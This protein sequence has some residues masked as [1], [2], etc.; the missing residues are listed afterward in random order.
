MPL[1]LGPITLN[2]IGNSMTSSKQTHTSPASRA[3]APASGSNHDNLP[4]PC[5][6]S[7]AE[8]SFHNRDR[9]LETL[10]GIARRDLG[11]RS[12]AQAHNENTATATDQLF[13]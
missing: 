8:E 12:S 7:E 11:L 2:Q 10:F 6:S 9:R 5:Q 3:G 13:S 1:P 4:R